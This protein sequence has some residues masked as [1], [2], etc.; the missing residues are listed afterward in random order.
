MFPLVFVK[1][2]A[3]VRLHRKC[4]QMIQAVADA[5]SETSRLLIHDF[6]DHPGSRE[7][8]SHILD[9]L[10]LHMMASLNTCSRNET[11]WD[12]I[13]EK[14]GRRLVKQQILYGSNGSAVL[15]IRL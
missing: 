1:P 10:D 5:M 12:A 3:Y 11:E 8:G 13:L 15:E 2:L 4:V 9:L 7:G 14:C 6:V